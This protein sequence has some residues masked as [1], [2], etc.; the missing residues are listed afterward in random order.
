MTVLPPAS[1]LAPSFFKKKGLL[2]VSGR[3][4][5]VGRQPV[6]RRGAARPQIAAAGRRGS[7]LLPA[8]AGGAAAG[9]GQVAAAEAGAEVGGVPQQRRGVG[10]GARVA[11]AFK[12]PH[13]STLCE[14]D[15]VFFLFFFKPKL[16][17]IRGS[18]VCPHGDE[19]YL[20]GAGRRADR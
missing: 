10:P 3:E 17:R 6:H 15:L 18:S 7:E 4:V 14:A 12:G 2:L 19:P 9:G 16:A 8:G 13:S 11:P 1:H 20:G 5:S